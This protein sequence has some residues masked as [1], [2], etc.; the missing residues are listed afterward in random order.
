ME[1]YEP[2]EKENKAKEEQKRKLADQKRTEK[3]I[4]AKNLV[5]PKV[6]LPVWVQ[7]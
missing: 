2:I 1:E 6:G 7:V 3:E 5:K 4:R